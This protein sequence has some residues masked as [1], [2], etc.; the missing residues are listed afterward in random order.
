M[1]L[2]LA[3]TNHLSIDKQVE[4]SFA[5]SSLKDPEEGLIECHAAPAG[6]LLP[7]LVIYGGN[8]A[9]KTNLVNAIDFARS[10]ILH[11]HLRVEA[12]DS[13]RRFPFLLR[14]GAE[15]EPT[16]CEFDFMLNGLRHHY[17]F[18][19][20]SERIESEWLY[21]FPST[22][23]RRLFDREGDDYL[24]GKDLKG[25]NVVISK[26]T[27]P[28]S[29]FLS[30]AGQ[31]GHDYLTQVKDVFASI[32]ILRNLYVPSHTAI[33]E[34]NKSGGIDDRVI[35]FLGQIDTGVV[36]CER[37]EVA[38]DEFMRQ[39]QYEITILINRL[40][41]QQNEIKRGDEMQ[42][43]YELVH[44]SSDGDLVA[45][46]LE[47][48]SAGTRRLLLILSA[49][50]KA[51][52]NGNLLVIDELD[53]SL[54]T[55]VSD[56][57]LRLFALNTSNKN[58][59]QLLATTHD[60]NLMG[61]RKRRVATLRRDQLWFVEKNEE[62]AT[63]LFPLTDFKTRMNDNFEQGYLEGRFGAVPARV[64]VEE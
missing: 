5:A 16:G 22:H 49:I 46:D 1:F 33:S 50:Y 40:L 12:G 30:M 56:A 8:A 54:H 31:T 4:L 64:A 28:N 57:V 42:T 17:G 27:R 47:R 26:L 38:V 32:E 55:R 44:R 24:F 21:Y 53:A 39:I 45:F 62:E 14:K 34:L 6:N 9:G 18:T 61:R 29:L 23:R 52:D 63:E 15:S 59:A 41:D 51:I 19:V 36:S 7:S 25:Q 35:D 3:F 11:S 2:R 48:E 43:I 58:G 10:A 37:K 20:S 13:V 60:T